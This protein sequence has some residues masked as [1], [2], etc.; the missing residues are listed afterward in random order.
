[1]NQTII[2]DIPFSLKT[3]QDKILGLKDEGKII[4]Q[5]G[6]IG[7]ATAPS[8]I[9]LLKYWGKVARREQIPVNSSLSYTLGGFRSFTKVTTLGRFL[10]D[11]EKRVPLYTNKLFLD[12]KN[13][14]NKIPEKMNRLVKSILYPY[15]QEISLQIESYNNFPTACGIASSA[16]GYAALVAAIA[17]LLQLQNHFTHAELS[18]WLTEWARLGSGSATRSTVICHEE[19]FIKWETPPTNH[20]DG[21][22]LTSNLKSHPKWRQL[23]HCVFILDNNEKE[24]SSS[25]GHKYADTSPFQLIR[26]AGIPARMKMMEKALLEFDFEAVQFLSEEDAYSMHA[27]MQTGNPKACYLNEKVA[28]V[29]SLFIELRN[30]HE[31]KAFWTLDAGPNIHI[32]F[33]PEALPMLLEFYER[34]K[35]LLNCEINILVNNLKEGLLMGRDEYEKI[36]KIKSLEGNLK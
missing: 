32:L 31:T 23:Q 29:I 34:I 4:V 14:E 5:N 15:A 2:K 11:G 27:V 28:K 21:F 25:D 13:N 19:S 6:D 8:N 7:Y 35:K 17:D 3:L 20:T 9:A 22:T 30:S 12:G 1:M 10:P 24:T 18:F 26:V 33:M 36:C 16:S